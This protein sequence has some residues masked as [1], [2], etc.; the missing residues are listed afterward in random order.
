MKR[1]SSGSSPEVEEERE[2]EVKHVCLDQDL[3]E[4]P[5]CIVEPTQVGGGAA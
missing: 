5:S 1:K 2:G 3:K 4:V